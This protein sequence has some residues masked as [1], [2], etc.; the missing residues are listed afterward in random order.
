[1]I[2]LYIYIFRSL[3]DTYSYNRKQVTNDGTGPSGTDDDEKFDLACVE[4]ERRTK[5]KQG[6]FRKFRKCWEYLR[7]KAKFTDSTNASLLSGGDDSSSKRKRPAGRDKSK[8]ESKMDEIMKTVRDKYGN[9]GNALA[10]T[11]KVFGDDIKGAITDGFVKLTDATSEAS[12]L[13][14]CDPDFSKEYATLKLKASLKRFRE[15]EGEEQ[16]HCNKNSIIG[17]NADNAFVLGN[18]TSNSDSGIDD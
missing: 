1:M 13:E 8:A 3:Y 18:G 4:F 16:K 6:Y 15:G 7:A 14:H 11:L 2:Y 5:K 10:N 9:N 12:Y 17:T